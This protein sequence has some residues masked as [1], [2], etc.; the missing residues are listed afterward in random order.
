MSS[1][2]GEGPEW[3]DPDFTFEYQQV[4]VKHA[5]SVVQALL[6]L[7]AHH[8]R[9]VCN[10]YYDLQQQR[11]A[12]AN[13]ADAA[14]VFE[15]PNKLLDWFSDM[16]LFQETMLKP[17]M[18]EFAARFRVG[19]WL[20]A[21][22]GIGPV[23]S[24][25]L[26]TFLDVRHTHGYEAAFFRYCGLNPK[27]NWDP[28]SGQPRPYNSRL[29]A[30]CLEHLGNSFIK[31]S[32]RDD[33]YYGHMYH[34]KMWDEWRRN[35][36]GELA[37]QAEA[38]LGR[39]KA[40]HSSARSWKSGC[41]DAK[42]VAELVHRA[43]EEGKTLGALLPN[44]KRRKAGE[45]TPMLPP[46]QINKRARRWMVKIFLSHYYNVCWLDA[47]GV[48]AKDPFVFT[49]PDVC[50]EHSHRIPPQHTLD[51]FEGKSL[52]ELYEIWDIDKERWEYARRRE[53]FP[54]KRKVWRLNKKIELAQQRVERAEARGDAAAAA[55][56][57]IVL[58]K[59]QGEL[60][61]AEQAEVRDMA[62]FVKEFGEGPRLTKEALKK[63]NNKRRK[64]RDEKSED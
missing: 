51:E 17:V 37:A 47:Y 55:K 13:R 61:K 21:H 41:Y 18:G 20:Q 43:Q 9:W 56:H 39:L 27:E 29:K 52:R 11:I 23:L 30:I 48:P 15:Q 33:C 10:L 49:R 12:T 64:T 58:D 53:L 44:L 28:K 22:M 57:K 42:E 40:V 38:E 62:K 3:H 32:G 2:F 54:S 63:I 4:N 16:N 59:R 25:A 50:G 46:D 6:Q 7:R 34:P 45:G 5:K 26:L 1:V 14:A 60:K 36:T 31:F 8:G 19:Q 35:Y 24:M